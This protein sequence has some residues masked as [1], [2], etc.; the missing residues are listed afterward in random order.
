MF[1]FLKNIF[2]G[3]DKQYYDVRIP[4]LI[5]GKTFDLSSAEKISTV[6]TCI[7]ILGKTLSKLPLEKYIETD[8][9]K[10]KDKQSPLY[11]LVH[12][13][14]NAYTTS[15]SFI[16]ALETNRNF[17]GNSFAYI[18]RDPASGRP[19]SLRLLLPGQVQGYYIENG[20]LYYFIQM[21][22]SKDKLTV[23]S[24]I[25]ILHFKMMTR[26]GIWG[27]NPIEA[28]RLN[29]S[30]TYKGM[31][32]IDTFYDNNATSPKALKS[33]ISGANQKA[34]LEALDKFNKDYSGAGNAGQMVP[35]PPNTEIQELKLN[36]GD[37]QFIETVK[38]N[39]NQI[40]ALFGIPAH[41]VG[42]TEASKFNNVEQMEIGFRAD[43]ISAIARMYRQEFEMKLL[44]TSQRA[45]GE[46]I[47]FNLN[48]MIDTDAQTRFE[49]YKVLASIGAISPNKIA[50]IENLE[51]DPAGDVRLVPMNFMNLEKIS[52]PTETQK[53]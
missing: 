16:N 52:K 6:Y 45:G 46:S 27:L 31:Q 9:G 32:T 40:A 38:F 12:Y 11:E 15:Q 29:L 19:V 14:P 8:Q 42:N 1:E 53:V 4:Q 20:S 22:L 13:N 28:L 43:T 49:G 23:V 41:M 35:L 7:D 51:T 30:T 33:T 34:M 47:E 44:T 36:F 18:E 50:Q 21:D 39:A 2:V 17:K 10:K 3:T 48:A 37:A 26:D 25:N 5:S 24:S